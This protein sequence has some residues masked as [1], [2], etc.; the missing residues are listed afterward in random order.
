MEKV[1]KISYLKDYNIT[2]FKSYHVLQRREGS[3][4][5]R[6][7][8]IY[9]Q[10]YIDILN[11]AM[12]NGLSSFRNK[13]LVAITFFDTRHHQ[14]TMLVEITDVIYVVSVWY[15]ANKKYKRV[16]HKVNQRIN[17]FDYVL[18][19][20]KHKVVYIRSK[21]PIKQRKKIRKIN[22]DEL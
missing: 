16:Y 17:L 13:G 7:H 14:Y 20:R 3:P 6:E 11:L 4:F 2:A 22:K 10:D 18:G 1:F 5:T 19:E 8:G 21:N 12:R 15:N 9:K